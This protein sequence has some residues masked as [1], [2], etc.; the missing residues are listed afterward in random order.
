MADPHH[1]AARDHERCRREAELLGAEQGADDDVAPG[2]ELAVDL[3]DDAVAHAVEHERLLR[4]GETQLPRGAGVLERVQRA[5]ARAAVVARHQD[6]VGQRLRGA[7]GDRA[8]ARLAHEL[9]VHASAGV[10]ALQIVDQLLEVFDRVDV[11]VRRRRDEPD[12][13][14]RVTR[15]RDP[16]VH[17]GRRQLAALAGL[18]TLGELDLDVVGLGEVQARDAEAPRG[19][20]LDRTAPLGVE[21]AICIFAALAGVGLAADAVHRDGQGLVSLARDRPVAHRAGREALDD[22]RH[23]LDLVDRHRRAALGL[24]REQTAQRLQLAG[25][26]VDELGVLAE[27]VVPAGARRVLQPEHRVGVEQVGR[28]VAAPLV[29]AARPEPLVGADGGILRV[30]VRVTRRVLGRDDVEADAAELGLGAGEVGVDEVVRQTD[31][32]EHLRAGVRRDGRDAHLRHD[33][34]HALAERVDQVLDGLLGRDPGDEA[35]AHEVLDGLHREVRVDGGCAVPDQ[36]RD[37][38]DLAHIACLDDEA[39]LHAR[40]LADEVVVHGGQHEQRRDGREVLVGVAVGEHDELRAVLDGLV[41]LLAHLLEALLHALVAGLDA[42]QAADR[43]RRPPGEGGVDVLDLGQLVVVDHRE[44]E[45]HDARVLG[46][47]FE[48]V[49]LRTEARGRGR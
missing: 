1:D 28:A 32:L 13:G 15:A 31:G 18:R 33:L 10:G 4:L 43:D 14:G 9:D 36:R 6:D 35:R 48:Q 25:L 44:V 49:A 20:L 21:Q 8:D 7:G 19:D 24:E 16:R 26:V 11:V 37:V 34:Q 12:A 3:H 17:L 40:L 2:L 41:D 23:R 47:P 38:M 45:R 39:A 27:D 46:A 42:V 5:R 22:R 30:R 29:L